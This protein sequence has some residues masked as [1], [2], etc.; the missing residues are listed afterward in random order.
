MLF[1][2]GQEARDEKLLFYPQMTQMTQIF[3]GVGVIRG[4]RSQSGKS[5][6]GHDMPAQGKRSAAQGEAK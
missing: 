3:L 1:C 4:N 2:V 5:P 6:N